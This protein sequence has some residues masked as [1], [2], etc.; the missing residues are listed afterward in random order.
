MDILFI[1]DSI[2]SGLA[3]PVE[4]GGESVPFGVLDIFPFVAQRQLLANESPQYIA[5]DLVAYPG[6]T[7]ISPTDQERE[8]GFPPGMYDAFFHVSH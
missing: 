7:L 2:S 8:N 5:I 3:V 6:F 4:D 1:G